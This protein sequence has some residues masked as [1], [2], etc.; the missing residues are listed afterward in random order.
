M[1]ITIAKHQEVYSYYREIPAF[2]NDADIIDFLNANNSALFKM[3]QKI[4]GLKENNETKDGAIKI[5]Q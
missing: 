1:E 5:S 3:K 4:T 2:N